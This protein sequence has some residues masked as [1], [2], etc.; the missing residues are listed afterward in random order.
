MNCVIIKQKVAKMNSG[1]IHYLN[2]YFAIAARSYPWES[3]LPWNTKRWF[4]AS[5]LVIGSNTFLAL[6]LKHDAELA[7]EV[8]SPINHAIQA[9]EGTPVV[10]CSN[11]SHRLLER[12]AIKHKVG[13]IIPQKFC[14][15]PSILMHAKHEPI[16]TKSPRKL[17]ILSTV[18]CVSYLEGEL[19]RCFTTG[20]ITIDTS[21]ATLSR[22]IQELEELDVVSVDRRNRQ[23]RIKFE[24]SREKI[25][26][27][28]EKLLSAVAS[29]PIH[30]RNEH[31]FDLRCVS[32]LSALSEYTNLSRPEYPCYAVFMDKERRQGFPIS[33]IN[34]DNASIGFLEKRKIEVNPFDTDS[35]RNIYVQIFPYRPQSSQNEN[36]RATSALLTYLSVEPGEPR[37]AGALYEL[38]DLIVERIKALDQLD[39]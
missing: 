3:P 24:G 26:G 21:K 27:A 9:V 19:E 16:N 23:H 10:V 13:L 25:W 22:A 18:I 6:H 2:D 36:Q 39:N 31:E 37:I 17:G 28:R 20:D 5:T 35:H 32:N 38:N 33:D 1:I 34:I 14:Y 15:L 4:E 11:H 12:I 29:K 7:E 8:L 30:I